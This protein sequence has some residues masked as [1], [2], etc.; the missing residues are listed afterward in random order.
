MQNRM[1]RLHP[2]QD[3]RDQAMLR[4][5]IL[6]G[7]ISALNW[8]SGTAIWDGALELNLWLGLCSSLFDPMA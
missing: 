2:Q 6:I 4:L 5:L 8:Y 7:L 1:Q 3:Q